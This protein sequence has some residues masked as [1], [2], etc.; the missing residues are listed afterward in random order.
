MWAGWHAAL[1][2]KGWRC[3]GGGETLGMK[4]NDKS[5]LRQGGIGWILLGLPLA[6][7]LSIG[8]VAALVKPTDS[9]FAAM[10]RFYAPIDWLHKNTFLKKPLEVY[11]ELWGVR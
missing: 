10:V 5:K 1:I 2:I 7:V 6:Y 8:P 11:L 3:M 9:N 4:T